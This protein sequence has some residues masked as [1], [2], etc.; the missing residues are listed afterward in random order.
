MKQGNA[1]LTADGSVVPV[2]RALLLQS[3]RNTL[4]QLRQLDVE[5]ILIAPPPANGLNLGKCL[6][7]SVLLGRN[8]DHCDFPAAELSPERI[9]IYQLL[10]EVAT[11]SRIIWLHELMC[12]KGKC[13]THENEGFLFL[14]EGHLSRDGSRLLGRK[15]DFYRLITEGNALVTGGEMR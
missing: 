15:Y 9:E 12:D 4:T 8:L 2:E 3:L 11:E 6:A 1:I 7:R 5:V 13:S 14:D 10:A